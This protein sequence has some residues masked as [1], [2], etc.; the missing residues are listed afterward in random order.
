MSKIICDVCGTA[1]PE[2]ASQCPICGSARPAD[3]M[4][5][6]GDN[7]Q[8]DQ[9][10]S[11]GYTYVKGG[12]FSKKNVRKRNKANQVA[13][14][15]ETEDPRMSGKDSRKES[16]TGLVITAVVLLLAIVAVVIYIAMRFFLPGSDQPDP[17]TTAGST[18]TAGTT[19]QSAQIPCTKLT[20]QDTA[21]EL[22]GVGQ[23]FQL[24]VSAEPADT[25]DQI[26]YICNNVAVATVSETGLVTAVAPG[27]A[28]ISIICGDIVVYCDVSCTDGTQTSPSDVTTV[29]P[30]TTEPTQPTTE[31]STQPSSQP[32]VDFELNRSDIT[33]S[34]KGDSWKLYSGGIALNQITWSTDD[35]SV[36]E[37]KNGTVTAVGKGTTKVY[38]EYGGKKVSCIIRCNLTDAEDLSE[39]T[40]PSESTAPAPDENGTYTISH[41]DVTISVGESFKLTLK[42]ANGNAVNVNWSADS[43]KVTIS[44]NTITGAASGTANVSAT[45]GGTTYTCIVR[46]K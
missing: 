44:G 7:T 2:T 32:N 23:A 36:A 38:G 37:I 17:G 20:S 31:P 1:Y 35:A 26:T 3:A 15:M 8:A 22:G 14:P 34:K 41:S 10:A 43:A 40:A 5:V 16:N 19:T 46:V 33:F 18:T 29:P 25:T 39:T 13:A 9:A 24:N 27:E 11:S 12:R 21:I 42:D 45:I 4:T 30:E 6:A 28:V